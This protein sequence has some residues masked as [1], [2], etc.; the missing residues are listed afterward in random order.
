MKQLI[1]HLKTL[2]CHHCDERDGDELFIKFNGKRIWPEKEKYIKGAD[3][4]VIPINIFLPVEGSAKIILQLWDYDLICN[5]LLG[6]F[7]FLADENGQFVCDLN[8]R[9]TGVHKF[10]LEFAVNVVRKQ[11]ANR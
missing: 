7:N 5:D 9:G 11:S 2:T 8:N 1:C 3:N 4:C 10:S 6:E